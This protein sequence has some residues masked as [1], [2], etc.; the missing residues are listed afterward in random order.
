MTN[1]EH[2][3]TLARLERS[4]DKVIVAFTVADRTVKVPNPMTVAEARASIA[5][6]IDLG[7]SRVSVQRFED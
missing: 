1:N 2:E 4:G 5:T 3:A 6:A 7:A